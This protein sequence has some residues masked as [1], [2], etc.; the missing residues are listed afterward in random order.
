MKNPF[1]TETHKA[2]HRDQPPKGRVVKTS[3]K[4]NIKKAIKKGKK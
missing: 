3:A 2:F 4:T 1:R